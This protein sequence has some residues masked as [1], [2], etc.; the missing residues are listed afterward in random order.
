MRDRIITPT[1]M[2]GAKS[3]FNEKCS[4]IGISIEDRLMKYLSENSVYTISFISSGSYQK[5]VNVD[6]VCYDESRQ[7]IGKSRLQTR[8]FTLA[9]GSSEGRSYK[10]K[11]S[12]SEWTSGE[13]FPLIKEI[14]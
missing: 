7:E 2:P 12:K 8:A 6:A 4:I 9:I 5:S 10:N 3:P 1:S 14:Y 13:I 11:F